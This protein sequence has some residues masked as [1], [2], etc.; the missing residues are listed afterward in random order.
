MVKYVLAGVVLLAAG[1][2]DLPIAREE[3]AWRSVRESSL[4]TMSP[5][6]DSGLRAASGA[7]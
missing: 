3:I 7:G 6:F 5:T 4:P 1:V 2:V